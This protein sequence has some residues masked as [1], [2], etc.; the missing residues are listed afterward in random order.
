CWGS[1]VLLQN[2]DEGENSDGEDEGTAVFSRRKLESNWDRYEEAERAEEENDMP[3]R[4][5]TDFH[6]LLESAGDSFTQ[7]RFSEEKNWEMDSSTMSVVILDLPALAESL[8]QVP[9]HHRLD[10][11]AEL[12]Q[13]G[14][15]RVG[16]EA[17]CLQ[18]IQKQLHLHAAAAFSQNRNLNVAAV[19][20]NLTDFKH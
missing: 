3:T 9:L 19:S 18:H 14:I 11:E 12:V 8:K 10:L 4:R 20:N 17:K 6:E 7:F 2:R 15:M 16:C 13:V 1:V 5:G